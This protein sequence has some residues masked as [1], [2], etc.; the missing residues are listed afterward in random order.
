MAETYRG[1]AFPWLCD[2]QGHLTTSQYMLMFDVASYHLMDLLTRG[3]G[4]DPALSWADVRHEIDYRAEV[5]V[6]SLVV[7]DSTIEAMGTS[8]L[9]AVHEM[10]STDGAVVHAR[11]LAVSVR[12]DK[13]ARRSAPLSLALRERAAALLPVAE[14]AA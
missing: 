7:I 10:R 11:M 2:Q 4:D 9:R 5:P 13:A 6:G 12:F 1:V 3:I 14:P 8:S